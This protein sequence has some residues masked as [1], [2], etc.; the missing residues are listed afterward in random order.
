[1]NQ[2][3]C[4]GVRLLNPFLGVLQ[5]VNADG[6]RALSRDGQQWEIQIQVERPGGGWGSLNRQQ[7]GLSYY[8][9]AFWSPSQGL[10][11]LPMNPGLD[12]DEM[13]EAADEMIRQ[14]QSGLLD[15]L[16]FA[17]A[18]R[19]EL[20]LLDQRQLPLALLGATADP[21]HI[22]GTH[23]QRWQ[24]V[25]PALNVPGYP[26]SRAEPLERLIRLTSEHRQWFHRRADG[27][28]IGMEAL[29]PRHLVGRVLSMECF[30]PMLVQEDWHEPEAQQR[31]VD[32]STHLAP[33]LL[34]LPDLSEQQRS[35]LE[36]AASCNPSMVAALHR[37][38]PQ[39]IDQQWL[40]TIRVAARL[41][42]ANG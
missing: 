39:V 40:N 23:A 29:C 9:Y 12:F 31:L 37:L 28:G 16:P 22:P 41:E 30:P 35:R 21:K 14:L 8:R 24:A 32:W 5:V 13:Q 7:R 2:P 33:W 11:R 25:S 10:R 19:Y 6:V 38:Y 26:P 42:T 20:W 3:D 4:Y 17:L 15:L 1:M 18:D 34:Q 27:S 36:Q